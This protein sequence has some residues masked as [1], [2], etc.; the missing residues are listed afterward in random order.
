MKDER[1]RRQN[2]EINNR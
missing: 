1:R 2:T